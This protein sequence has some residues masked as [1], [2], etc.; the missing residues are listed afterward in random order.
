MYSSTKKRKKKITTHCLRAMKERGERVVM[1]TAYDAT[2]AR[3]IDRAGVEVILVGDSLGMVFQ[4]HRSTLPVTVEHIIYHTAAVKR[5]AKRA[6]VVADMP[7]GS[8]QVSP[9]DALRNAARIMKESGAEAVKLEGGARVLEAVRRMTES[10][11][12]VMGHVGLTP[13]SVHQ[14]GGHKIQGREE[15]A[16]RQIREDAL[17]LQEAGCF[18]LVMEAIPQ[19]LAGT[20]TSDLAIPT[21]GIGAGPDCDGQVLVIYD[22]LGMD[23]RFEP[24]FLK[25]YE[26]LAGTISGAVQNYAEE[27]RDG[28]FPARENGFE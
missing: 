15:R 1:L 21:I 13:Q 9:D 11:I 23:E 28:A 19:A 2:F 20:I 12:P 5:G 25:K 4:G 16:G 18:S 22:L 6:L 7:F 8:Y 27:V 26:D 14:L 3:L 24:Q 17:A 10:G